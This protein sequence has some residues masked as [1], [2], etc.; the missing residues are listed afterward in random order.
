VKRFA[1]MIAAAVAI[2]IAAAA[3]AGCAALSEKPGAA[4]DITGVITSVDS[5]DAGVSA[6]VVW[7][8]SVGPKS[9]SRLDVVQ[10]AIPKDLEVKNGSGGAGQAMRP[11]DLKVGDIVAVYLG[12]AIA[13]SY[14]PQGTAQAV[15]YLGKHTGEL[16]KVPG[17]EPPTFA[18][19]PATT[20]TGAA[21]ASGESGS[22][23][24]A[25]ST[26]DMPQI[27]ASA[28]KGPTE[29]AA[30]V[31]ITA[32]TPKVADSGA[33]LTKMSVTNDFDSKV[34]G[35]FYC[36]NGA[37]TEFYLSTDANA[38]FHKVSRNEW[39]AKV[40]SKACSLTWG[41]VQP[42]SGAKVRFVTRADWASWAN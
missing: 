37:D 2:A 16:P 23:G 18:T 26:S 29:D 5:S 39:F 17:L 24:V 35:T 15:M 14:P 41:W 10:V 33:G 31:T 30:P 36:S 42:S 27:P 38:G 32:W 25:A 7:D 28:M 40:G 13:E 34:L 12:G 22:G 1:V 4:P 8:A 9:E 11:A 3:L 21:T 20:S 19:D 6:R